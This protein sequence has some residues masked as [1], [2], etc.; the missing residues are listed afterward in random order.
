M[1]VQIMVY[2]QYL[3]DTLGDFV[4]TMVNTED[5]CEVDPGKLTNPANIDNHQQ[6]LDMYCNMV[7]TK[8]ISSSCYF[9]RFAS[10]IIFKKNENYKDFIAC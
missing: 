2:L 5:D 7:W 10:I 9:P 8:I 3:R 4:L 1:K 6:L